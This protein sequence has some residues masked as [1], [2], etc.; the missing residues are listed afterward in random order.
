[1][2]CTGDRIRRTSITVLI[3]TAVLLLLPSCFVFGYRMGTARQDEKLREFLRVA[4]EL[5]IIDRD[6]LR[7]LTE[8]SETYDEGVSR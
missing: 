3:V 5:G 6:R 2:K 1:M 7:E 4:D 8:G